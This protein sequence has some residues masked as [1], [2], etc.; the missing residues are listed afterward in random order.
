MERLRRELNAFA[1][2]LV[3]ESGE[4]I[5]QAGELPVLPGQVTLDPALKA[6]IEASAALSNTIGKRPP[7]DL[8]C[9]SGTHFDLYMAHA[10]HSQALVALTPPEA[11]ILRLEKTLHILLAAANA[12]TQDLSNTRLADLVLTPPAKRQTDGLATGKLGALLSQAPDE[13][14]QSQEVDSFW[15]AAA[16][17]AYHEG[18]PRAGSLSYEQARKLGLT[19]QEPE[20]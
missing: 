19:P 7:E 17:Q 14:V 18:L 10:G 8:L 4:T 12:L 9:V 3:T 20:K 15:E 6:L 2:L 16:E 11:G 5:N 1:V 13:Q